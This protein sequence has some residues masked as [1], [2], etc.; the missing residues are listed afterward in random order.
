[1]RI[2]QSVRVDGENLDYV[3]E[4]QKNQQ[5]LKS[6]F[7]S[8]FEKFG[9]IHESQSDEIDMKTN[10][11]VVDRGHLRRL[12]RQSKGK[13]K[14]S[15]DSLGVAVRSEEEEDGEDSEDE[16]APTQLVKS[17]TTRPPQQDMSKR[18]VEN[19]LINTQQP[20]SPQSD[21]PVTSI[22][23]LGVPQ[24]PN[25]QLPQP[26]VRQEAPPAFY[27]KLLQTIN[28]AVHQLTAGLN[29]P[30]TPTTFANATP[31]PITPMTTND[32]V[33]PATDPKWFF[34][35]L[36]A[37][38]RQCSPTRS[39]RRSTRV[40]GK[41]G[42]PRKYDFN[43][44]DDVYIS[45][46]RRIDGISW[47]AIKDDRE[48]WKTWPLSALYNHWVLIKGRNLHLQEPTVAPA[49]NCSSSGSRKRVHASS[50]PPQSA[51]KRRSMESRKVRKRRW[52][53]E[54]GEDGLAL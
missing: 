30:N 7:E 49:D 20:T 16:L 33:A 15:L 24:T 25:I 10:R 51:G 48:K 41:K 45:K 54:W 53:D 12:Q 47:K 35:P 13:E 21:V 14:M 8:I 44:E 40:G 37:E 3:G 5:R 46:C 28:Q 17:K 18:Q 36:P 34:P 2:H 39:R 43:H 19:I 38:P 52:E 9:N 11:V 22:P 27:A 32:K 4:K 50:K 29:I 26:P 1:M 31:A 42:R 23:Q 6:Q